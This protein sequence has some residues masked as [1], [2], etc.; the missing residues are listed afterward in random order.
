MNRRLFLFAL[1]CSASLLAQSQV[2]AGFEAWTVSIEKRVYAGS[3][4]RQPGE[5]TI[6]LTGCRNE[7]LTAQLACRNSRDSELSYQASA[8]RGPGGAE[9]PA[10][11]VRVRFGAYL[12][13]DETGQYTA[14]PL[15]ESKTVRLPANLAQPVWITIHVPKRVKPGA[16]SGALKLAAGGQSLE[17]PLQIE[18]LSATLPDPP[19]YAFYLNLWQ[20]PNGVA[21]AHKAELWS[22]SH[23]Q[24]LA[25]YAE[26]LAAHGEKAIMTSLIH[27]PWNAQ[28][29][30]IFPTMVEWKF[31]GE[32][33]PG[34]ESKFQWDF[35]LF[36][37][38][39]NTMMK[40][41]VRG[42]IDMYAMVKGPG[43]T[44]DASIR[45]FD[46]QARTYRDE[47]LKVGDPKWKAAWT[48][49]L[50]ILKAH[51]EEKGW[52][53]IAYLGCD[54]KPKEI[55]DQLFE[56]IGRAG[57][58]YKLV[59][60]GGH[61]QAGGKNEVVLYWDDLKNDD[62]W[63]KTFEPMV[64]KFH[65]NGQLVTFYTACEPYYPNTFLFSTLRE[66]RLLAWIARKYNVLGY[67][68]WAVNAYPDDVWSQPNFKWHSGDMY[69]VYPGKDGPLD[70]MRWELIRQGIQDYEAW[71][72]AHEMATFWGRNDLVKLLNGAVDKATV[73]DS[74]RDFPPV[75][76]AREIVN[77]VLR[78]IGTPD[79]M[80]K[81]T[82]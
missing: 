49:F 70:G 31:P 32:W 82:P 19:D 68:R 4:S 6:K 55:M 23:W 61:A 8:L 40:A 56:F 72:I 5:R 73:L 35:T 34:G 7:F 57:P 2:P 20:D 78:E 63:K 60:S 46:T 28:T 10:A 33:T 26:N 62:Q 18:V 36:D 65:E 75:A 81:K 29:G 9:I 24:I 58:D 67:T 71:R 74:C 11:A 44:P 42:K 50:P 12:P 37:R 16:Y 80:G 51:L 25:R 52:W 38:Y 21:R 45:Y 30:Y 15:L 79:E 13:V 69:F 76:E 77:A 59:M 27:D 39:V 14:D 17:A 54:E 43:E 1:S 41:G 22:E 47:K 64:R 66:S 48:A 3:F 53:K